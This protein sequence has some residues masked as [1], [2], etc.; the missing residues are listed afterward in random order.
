MI[1]MLIVLLA[2][3]LLFVQVVLVLYQL[4]QTNHV[5]VITRLSTIILAIILVCLFTTH[6]L[7]PLMMAK[8]I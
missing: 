1:V 5:I 7:A 8:T 2:Q 3:V 6:Q 4:D